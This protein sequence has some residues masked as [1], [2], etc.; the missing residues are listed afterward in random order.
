MPCD[1]ALTIQVVGLEDE[2]ILRLL[3]PDLT[4]AA[5]LAALED[6]GLKANENWRTANEQVVSLYVERGFSNYTVR[7]VAGQ[8]AVTGSSAG[9]ARKIGDAI[10][11]AMRELGIAL[12]GNTI[13]ATM[14]ELSGGVE[15]EVEEVT[16]EQDGRVYPMQRLIVSW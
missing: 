13:A 11:M 4:L 3:T 16:G 1:R 15:P 7:I 12:L 6:L 5:A 9:E 2:A 8:V 14:R 10:G